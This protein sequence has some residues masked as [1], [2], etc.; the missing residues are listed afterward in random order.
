MFKHIILCIRKDHNLLQMKRLHF[1][2]KK[3]DVEA[4]KI[5]D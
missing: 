5:G 4:H 3:E 1:K 2:E